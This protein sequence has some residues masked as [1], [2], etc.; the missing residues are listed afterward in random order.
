MARK[1]RDAGT[2]EFQGKS[3]AIERAHSQAELEHEYVPN[4]TTA[5]KNPFYD[6]LLESFDDGYSRGLMVDPEDLTT[7]VRR[8][9]SATESINRLLKKRKEPRIGTDLRF[10]DNPD[11][12]PITIHKTDGNEYKHDRPV[13]VEFFARPAKERR[14]AE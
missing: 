9:K 1:E 8:I 6:P 7:V 10:R 13:Y 5:T 3:Y 2:I 4:G 14:K 11:G 12:D